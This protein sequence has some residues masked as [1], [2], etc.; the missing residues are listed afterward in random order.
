MI[1]DKGTLSQEET[2]IIIFQTIIEIVI[3]LEMVDKRTHVESP[4]HLL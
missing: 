4:K 2:V 1:W 3:I